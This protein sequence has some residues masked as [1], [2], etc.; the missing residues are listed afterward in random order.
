[1]SS[2]AFKVAGAAIAGAALVRAHGHVEGINV[3][4]VYYVGYDPTTDPYLST[5]PTV[6]GWTA[7]DTDNGY[8]A[9][10]AYASGDIICHVDATNAAGYASVQAGDTIEAYWTAWPESHKGPV[11]D[12]L[13]SCDGDCTTVDKTTLEFF[14]IAAVGLVD[15]T[16]LPGTWASD[17]LIANNNSWIIQIPEDLA[18]GNYVWRHEIIALHSAEN[19]DG[20]QNYPQCFNL[21]VTGT[22]TL[23]PT[24]TLG[25]ALYSETDAGILVD[26]YA[27]LASYDIPGPT[28]IAAGTNLVQSAISVTATSSAVTTGVS[29]SGSTAAA[30]SAAAV[31]SAA[32][33]SA[34]AVATSATS[35]AAAVATSAASSAAAVTTEATSS[36]AAVA[37]EAT[38][39]A[40]AATTSAASNN[41]SSC[42]KRRHARELRV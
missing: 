19:S 34:A 28:Q 41:A 1:M 10:D 5:S 7:S 9:P 27:S 3:N 24:G 26:I 37:T 21:A 8:V 22:G 12:M 31:T 29:G 2:L 39:S 6:V 13:A 25:E 30:T 35:S 17:N 18:P 38:S 32:T 33:S 42:K 4:G 11:I 15:D 14:K 36:A 16:T 40:A 20:A 23:A